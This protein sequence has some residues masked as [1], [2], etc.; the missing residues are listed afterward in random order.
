MIAAAAKGVLGAGFR[1][2]LVV[3]A[4]AGRIQPVIGGHYIN[5]ATGD[6]NRR[7]FNAFIA[8]RDVNDAA[9]DG[10]QVIRMDAVITGCNRELAVSDGDIAVAVHRVVRSIDVEGASVDRY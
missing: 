8:L 6:N 5:L 10:C 4:A 3:D 9:R 2:C 7:A 1:R